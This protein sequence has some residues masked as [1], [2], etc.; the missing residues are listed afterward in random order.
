M[1]SFDELGDLRLSEDDLARLKLAKSKLEAPS[2]T[3]RLSEMVGRRLRE[4]DFAG[5]T[6]TLVVRY[7]DMHTFS[8]RRT[9]F[10][11]IDDGYAIYQVA[12]SILREQFGN[13]RAIRLIGVCVSNLMKGSQL[14]LF[15]DAKNRKLLH[16]MD[17]INDKYGEFTIRRASLMETKPRGRAPNGIAGAVYRG[18]LD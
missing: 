16:A 9:I 8:R 15:A 5:R 11:H 3:A 14:S 6:I 13:K 2:L 10:E 18:N 1:N 17:A 4:Q 12:L 7:A